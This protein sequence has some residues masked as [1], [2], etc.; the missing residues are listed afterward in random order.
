MLR[1]PGALRC[2]LPLPGHSGLRVALIA[3]LA[4]FLYGCESPV[5]TLQSSAANGDQFTRE[6]T[7]QYRAF[8]TF[9][10][11]E[12]VDWPDAEHFARKGLLA[13]QGIAVEPED[14]NEWRLPDSE[15]EALAQARDRLAW[16]LAAGAADEAPV[17]A[18]TALARF[19]CWIE[20]PGRKLATRTHRGL[21]GRILCLAL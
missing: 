2:W 5:T 3:G 7:Q 15:R 19:D 20:Q 17:S 9:E 14:I 10:A 18:A 21:S 13:A 4:V 16:V 6:L 1:V 12:M 11:E 8:A